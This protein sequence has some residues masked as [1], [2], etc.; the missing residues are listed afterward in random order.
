MSKKLFEHHI[1]KQLDVTLR[2]YRK[3]YVTNV[4]STVFIFRYYRMTELHKS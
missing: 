4:D 2:L 3:F 1:F